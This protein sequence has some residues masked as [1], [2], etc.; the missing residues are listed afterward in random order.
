MLFAGG[1]KCLFIHLVLDCVPYEIALIFAHIRF[2]N[3][4][5]L[6]IFRRRSFIFRCFLS[7]FP[8]LLDFDFIFS[9]LSATILSVKRKKRQRLL[10]KVAY[11][12]QLQQHRIAAQDNRWGQCACRISKVWN[13]TCQSTWFISLLASQRLLLLSMHAWMLRVWFSL[14]L[15]MQKS[16]RHRSV[17]WRILPYTHKH[18]APYIRNIN[19]RHPEPESKA[20]VYTFFRV[21]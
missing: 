9:R 10:R 6:F 14:H 3:W 5:T 20:P 15:H 21:H 8:D 4:S 19:A 1:C 12:A 13:A 18:A 11:G 7:R 17:A 16:S 2:I